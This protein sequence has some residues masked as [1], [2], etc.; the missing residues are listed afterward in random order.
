MSILFTKMQA[1][2]NDFVVLDHVRQAFSI[3]GSQL[4]QIADRHYG[5]GCDQILIIGSTSRPGV[6]FKYRIFNADG[7]EVSQCGNGVRCVA[8][9]VV[10]K[11]LTD[12][13]EIVVETN[14]GQMRLSLLP[15]DQVVVEMGIPRFSPDSIPMQTSKEK[16]RYTVSLASG[17]VEFSTVS[18]GNPH[19]VI[20]VED[21]KAAPVHSIGPEMEL[22]NLF[23][24]RVNV[25]FMQVLGRGEIDL[26]V[27]ERGV[28]ETLACGSGACAAVVAG[29]RLKA[30]DKD[31][32]VN[33][34]GGS[35]NIS[36]D[37]PGTQVLM[38]GP[39]ESVF[40]GEFTLS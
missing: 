1:L 7:S 5:V 27:W 14:A 15:D 36:W 11:G 37:G 34:T 13:T 4:R 23:P 12:Q 2:G 26:R 21:I 6:D 35:L 31:V 24:D 30:L 29:Q 22:N 39:A 3:S 28:G 20:S 16:K 9:F 17:E 40:D 19:A 33:L 18:L 8:R 38:T 10:D 25:G 32:V